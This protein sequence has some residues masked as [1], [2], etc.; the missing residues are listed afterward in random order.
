MALPGN[1]D[2]NDHDDYAR[3]RVDDGSNPRGPTTHTVAG[4]PTRVLG[5]VVAL[6]PAVMDDKGR[7]FIG[8]KRR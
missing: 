4:I 6:P 1:A 8:A 5:L 2:V 3:Q 7:D